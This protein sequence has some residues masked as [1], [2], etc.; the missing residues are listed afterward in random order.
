LTADNGNRTRF[1]HKRKKGGNPKETLILL[2]FSAFLLLKYTFILLS[3]TIY[4]HRIYTE[5]TQNLHRKKEERRSTPLWIDCKN[6]A[7][8]FGLTKV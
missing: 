4:L 7:F 1:T 8:D 5:I 2:G 6:F 3:Y